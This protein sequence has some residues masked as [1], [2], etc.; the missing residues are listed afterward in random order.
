MFSRK[1]VKLAGEHEDIC[2][3][4][5][6]MPE[7]TGLD[8]FS[9]KYPDR[10]FDV[11]IAEQHAV[12]FAAGLASMGYR[13]FVAIYSSFLQRAFDQVM[14]DV[15]IQNLPVTFCI[16]R[17]GLVGQDGET[18]QGIFDLSYLNVIPN[19]NILAPKN[20]YELEDAVAFAA[21][22]NAPLAIRYPRGAADD[23][24]M[25]FREPIVLGRSEGIYLEKDIAIISVGTMMKTALEVRQR[26][27]DRGLNVTLI[28]ARFVKP[29]DEK[30]IDDLLADHHCLITMEENVIIGGYGMSVLRHIN[31]I[32]AQI[33][34]IPIALP[35]MYVEQGDPAVQKKE[36][37]IDADSIMRRL[38]REL[39]NRDE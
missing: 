18:H 22:F 28:N 20:R 8:R 1:L 19:M 23:A 31:N 27:K 29:I 33:R 36:C 10:Y 5:A 34:V 13:P 9:R 4:C 26:L 11:G 3:I 37:R 7:G 32:G 35:N 16:D 25:Q 15:C 21:E 30:L 17:A 38:E 14:H 2:A 12:T 6:A 39:L 24:A